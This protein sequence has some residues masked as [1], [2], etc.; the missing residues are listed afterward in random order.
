MTEIAVQGGVSIT[1]AYRVLKSNPELARQRKDAMAAADLKRAK[2]AWLELRRSLPAHS[3]TQLRRAS[4][5][6]YSY[7]Y[8]HDRKWLVE[9]SPELIRDATQKPRTTRIPQGADEVLARRIREIAQERKGSGLP[10]NDTRTRLASLAGR[11]RLS[12]SLRAAPVASAALYKESESLENYVFR[13]LSQAVADLR[14]RGVPLMVW[15]VVR[16]AR[17]R[18]STIERSGVDVQEVIHATR[19]HALRGG[20][21]AKD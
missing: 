2:Q 17:L 18:S 10:P 14:N 8:R 6:A 7:L 5:A 4:S 20:R 9:N 1:S 11:Q 19:A 12:V 16:E 21:R 15:R 13:R 3:T